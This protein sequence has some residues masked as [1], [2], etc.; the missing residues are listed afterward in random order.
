MP[1]MKIINQKCAK[2]VEEEK[3]GH[4]PRDAFDTVGR[5]K[6]RRTSPKQIDGL[7]VSELQWADRQDASTSYYGYR[8]TI[9]TLCFQAAA[10][11][12]CSPTRPFFR[13]PVL[14]HHPHPAV[15]LTSPDGLYPKHQRH[16]DIFLAHPRPAHVY[17]STGVPSSLTAHRWR[18]A[19]VSHLPHQGIEG[20]CWSLVGWAGSGKRARA[21]VGLSMGW[22]IRV[23]SRGVERSH[24]QRTI[25]GVMHPP[26]SRPANLCASACAC[27]LGV[28]GWGQVRVVLEE[29]R[30]VY[31]GMHA[32]ALRVYMSVVLADILIS[33]PAGIFLLPATGFT[34]ALMVRTSQIV[35]SFVARYAGPVRDILL[36]FSSLSPLV[37]NPGMGSD[38]GDLVVSQIFLLRLLGLNPSAGSA[39]FVLQYSACP[40]SRNA[41]R[42]TSIVI[43]A[44]GDIFFIPHWI[45][46]LHPCNC[47]SRATGGSLKKWSVTGGSESL[48]IRDIGVNLT[49]RGMRTESSWE[50]RKI[51]TVRKEKS[52]GK[53]TRAVVND[54]SERETLG[55][56]D[57]WAGTKWLRGDKGWILPDRRRG[58]RVRGKQSSLE[59]RRRRT[60]LASVMAPNQSKR[61]AK[62]GDIEL[63][64]IDT[65]YGTGH[66][67][68]A[69]SSPYRRRHGDVELWEHIGKCREGRRCSSQDYPNRNFD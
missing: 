19:A 45:C 16:P 39:M 25:R 17:G 51:K 11:S 60:L 9:I 48:P 13:S 10:A 31:R 43:P 29:V 3:N 67:G 68:G 46:L 7:Y 42:I 4:V 2:G 63:E 23:R 33:P 34:A 66:S 50:A 27:L 20:C 64:M 52:T 47:H 6:E 30:V 49:E 58:S 26:D 35:C 1:S 36:V 37:G 18:C 24:A 44:S 65:R 12:S 53:T 69:R 55:T 21:N 62:L 57:R 56:N 41:L 5:R 22:R 54:G 40:G 61:V 38:K 32:D 8:C 28:L 59:R 15:V 14:R